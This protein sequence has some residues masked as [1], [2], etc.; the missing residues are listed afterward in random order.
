M[1]ASHLPFWWTLV[2]WLAWPRSKGQH[3]H[4]HSKYLENGDRYKV[5]PLE[6]LYV[7]PTDFRLAPSDL[8]LR[9]Q[10]SRSYFLTRGYRSRSQSFD[11]KYL[12]NGDRYE[13][14]PPEHLHVGPTG[15]RLAAS[16]LTLDDLEGQK[17]RS[18]FLTWNI[19]RMATVT[20]LDIMEIT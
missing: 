15:F 13:V 12:E 5:R 7:G 8:T 3:Q 17:S 11:S 1:V 19:S 20:M 16:D 6:H 4:F 18:Y 14:G 2:H 10:K 9:G